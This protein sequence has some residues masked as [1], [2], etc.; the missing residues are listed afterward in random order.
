LVLAAAAEPSGD[1]LLLQRAADTLGLDMAAIGPAVDA[2][3][4]A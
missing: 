1:P 4:L 2:G 3:L